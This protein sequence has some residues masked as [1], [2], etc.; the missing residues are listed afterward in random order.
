MSFIRSDIG[1]EKN[2]I[3]DRIASANQCNTQDTIQKQ[4]LPKMY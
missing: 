2:E 4:I 1:Q 3:V